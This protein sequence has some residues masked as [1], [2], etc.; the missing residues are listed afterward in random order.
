MNIFSRL[1]GRILPSSSTIEFSQVGVVAQPAGLGYCIHDGG[2]SAELDDSGSFHR[3]KHR[4]PPAIDLLDHDVD[5][6]LSDKEGLTLIVLHGYIHNWILH[7]G[8]YAPRYLVRQFVDSLSRGLDRSARQDRYRAVGPD[9]LGGVEILVSVDLYLDNILKAKLIGSP[10]FGAQPADDLIAKL[11][12]RAASRLQVAGREEGDLAIR[13]HGLRP[14]QIGLVGD[15]YIHDIV[16]TQHERSDVRPGVRT[17]R[18]GG[19]LGRGRRRKCA[20]VVQAR[21]ERPIVDHV[22]AGVAARKQD[23]QRENAPQ[24]SH[25][26]AGVG[27]PSDGHWLHVRAEPELES[28]GKTL[29]YIKERAPIGRS[30]SSL[31]SRC[32]GPQRSPLRT[33]PLL[34]EREPC[35]RRRI[36]ALCL[37]VL[38]GITS[39]SHRRKP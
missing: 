19:E 33:G 26:Q 35:P 28:S 34:R 4:N 38:K 11:F 5:Q 8:R 12:Y 29:H 14:L 16:W 36:G 24:D 20:L 22:R 23:S 15:R 7:N 1:T 32:S 21:L 27:F 9:G 18:S 13:A 31:S 6:R 17:K 3:A 39:S 25:A 37:S 30:L 2:R 10:G